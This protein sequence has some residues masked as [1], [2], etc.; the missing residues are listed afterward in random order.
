ML[1]GVCLCDGG[2]SSPTIRVEPDANWQMLPTPRDA[3]ESDENTEPHGTAANVP[4]TSCED[5]LPE[6]STATLAQMLKPR[7]EVW[8]GG[9][10]A[11]AVNWGCVI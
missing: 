11:M 1:G 4:L 3:A 2:C 9:D 5:K 8:T 10:D 6:K 7:A